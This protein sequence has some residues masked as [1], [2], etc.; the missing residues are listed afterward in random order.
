[1]TDIIKTPALIFKLRRYAELISK[2]CNFEWMNARN[3]AEERFNAYAQ[4][5]AETL[6]STLVEYMVEY[7]D[8]A[9]NYKNTG[10][11]NYLYQMRKTEYC[12][13]MIDFILSRKLS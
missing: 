2:H 8:H 3:N 7:S 10:N 5:S 4:M 13:D 11:E 9:D 6:N 12:I 1:M